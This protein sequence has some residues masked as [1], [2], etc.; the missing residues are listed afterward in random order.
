MKQS[1]GYTLIEL[2]ITVA[3]IGIISSIAIPAYNDYLFTSRYSVM[4][5]HLETL[6]LF[7]ESYRLNNSTY[8]DGTMT[9]ATMTT[10]VLATDLQFFP[11]VDGEQF[12]YTVEACP[13]GTIDVCFKA[14]VEWAE[15][16]NEY[17]L[18]KCSGTEANHF[19]DC[20]P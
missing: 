20:N 4:E 17:S 9:K 8:L 3:I 1:K 19:E 14:T 11:G 10:S 6:R 2:M 5:D 16:P 13:N 7:E 18:S 12:I 15:N